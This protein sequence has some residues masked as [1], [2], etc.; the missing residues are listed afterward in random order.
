MKKSKIEPVAV[1]I[2]KAYTFNEVMD[3]I[4]RDLDAEAKKVAGM[5]PEQLVEYQKECAIQEAKREEILKGLRGTP[6]F[7]EIRFAKN[8]K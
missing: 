3:R 2:G 5:T 8:T 1:S 6:G 4:Q 7:T